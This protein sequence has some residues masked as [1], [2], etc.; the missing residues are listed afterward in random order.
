MR[1]GTPAPRQGRGDPGAMPLRTAAASR[2]ASSGG[3]VIGLPGGLN[4]TR[5]RIWP[6]IAPTTRV[7][8]ASMSAACVDAAEPLLGAQVGGQDRR[9]PGLALAIVRPVRLVAGPPRR[10]R[11]RRLP[12]S[13]AAAASPP[14]VDASP[15]KA[16]SP[17]TIAWKRLSTFGCEISPAKAGTTR[18]SVARPVSMNSAQ[19]LRHG[20]GPGRRHRPRAGS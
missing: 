18:V 12:A 9:Q 6:W 13:P 8:A 5:G 7:T 1:G 17:P 15:A 3:A 19:V 16:A 4:R 2:P 14:P 11:S 20:P 10:R